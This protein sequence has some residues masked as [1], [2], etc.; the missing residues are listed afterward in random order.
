MSRV[1]DYQR[2]KVY[3]AEDAA[4]HKRRDPS[5]TTLD[6]VRDYMDAIIASEYWTAQKGWLRVKV[7]DG[8]GRRNACYKPSR[9]QVCFPLWARSEWIIIHEMAHCLTYRTT[10]DGTGHGTHFTGHYLSLVE[11]LLGTREAI[12]LA[13]SFT[14]HGVRWYGWEEPPTKAAAWEQLSLMAA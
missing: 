10:K 4:F 13:E 5:M 6:E 2:S 8:R 12:A 14:K 1:S 9:R 11:E 7:G 3:A